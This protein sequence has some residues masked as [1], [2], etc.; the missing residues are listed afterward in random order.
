MNRPTTNLLIIREI[1][2]IRDNPR[3]GAYSP[4][5]DVHSNNLPQNRI[6]LTHN[7]KRLRYSHQNRTI[8]LQR[9]TPQFFSLPI[10]QPLLTHLKD[11]FITLCCRNRFY[12]SVAP[13]QVEIVY[14]ATSS[15]NP[16]LYPKCNSFCNIRQNTVRRK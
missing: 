8:L 14:G 1:R 4:K 9:R 10:P 11:I 12:L 7:R 3:F 6:N 2:V 15:S 5:C 16:I 13:V